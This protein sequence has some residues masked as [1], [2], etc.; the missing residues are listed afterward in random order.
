MKYKFKDLM[1]IKSGINVTRIKDEDKKYLYTVVD[2]L[3]DLHG[4]ES[5]IEG[6]SDTLKEGDIL[7]Q[8]LKASA[9]VVS[10][11][12][13]KKIVSANFSYCRSKEEGIY[14]PWYLCYAINEK[15]EIRKQIYELSR[16]STGTISR[17]SAKLFSEL[18]IDLPDLSL[19]KDLAKL[20]Q[21]TMRLNYLKE[22]DNYISNKKILLKMEELED[23]YV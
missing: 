1:D 18:E 20:Y 23:K 11:Y 8:S 21:K 9:S 4:V 10:K 19:Q 14:D 2:M 7:F 13:C 17:L 15:K 12:T 3:N 16:P 5:E 6:N 22:K